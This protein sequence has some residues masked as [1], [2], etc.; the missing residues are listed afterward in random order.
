M[1]EVLS[2]IELKLLIGIPDRW[3]ILT[4]HH[5]R[6]GMENSAYEQIQGRKVKA[7]LRMREGTHLRLPARK[8]SPFS[9]S[10]LIARSYRSS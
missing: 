7:R 5:R 6:S 4:A 2:S 3:G 9:N 1:P 8:G 10:F